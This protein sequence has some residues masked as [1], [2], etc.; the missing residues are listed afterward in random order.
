MHHSG[1]YLTPQG[2]N[3]A[4]RAMVVR[5]SA[6][7]RV[8]VCAAA[9]IMVGSGSARRR[10]PIRPNVQVS[11]FPQGHS[12]IGPCLNIFDSWSAAFR[13]LGCRHVK[14]KHR[15]A[16]T[17]S[18]RSGRV[19]Q[20]AGCRRKVDAYPSARASIVNHQQ[21]HA[22]PRAFVGLASSFTKTVEPHSSNGKGK[23]GSALA[24][25]ADVAILELRDGEF[26]FLDNYENQTRRHVAGLPERHGCSPGAA[27]NGDAARLR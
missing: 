24:R 20:T 3:R 26:E 6:A 15:E 23:S 11:P 2:K 17:Q 1:V 22:V 12:H 14:G 9:Q 10:A 13:D 7:M 21:R 25:L 4:D 27:S 16:G 5:E 8:T 18:H 19:G